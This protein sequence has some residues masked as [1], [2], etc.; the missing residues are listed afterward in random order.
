MGAL[1][2]EVYYGNEDNWGSYQ[3]ICLED[4]VNNFILTYTGDDTLLGKV[5]RDK[6]IYQ[7]KTGIKEF[8]YSIL[9]QP[10]VIELELTDNYD[11]I[12]P[13]DYVN[14][15]RISWVDKRTGKIH[16]MSVNRHTP[17]GV[18]YLQDNSA[19]VLFDNNGQILEGTTILEATNDNLT[20]PPIENSQTFPF[21]PNLGFFT[22]Y[23]I[24]QIWNLDTTKNFNGTFNIDNK[25]I[26]F[27]TDNK[28][29]II[30]L[31]YISDGLAGSENEMC[32]PKLA[33]TALYEFIHYNLAKN[34]IRIPDYEKRNIK[35]AYDTAYRNARLRMLNIK[36]QEFIAQ[37]RQAKIWVR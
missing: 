4:I 27:S 10:K 7:A 22:R 12:L 28:E 29:R 24:E 17:L 21:A 6:V 14:Y 31:E 18:A 34:S 19:S 15:I 11:I 35:K 37:L 5:E 3:F 1:N 25:R 8:T 26:H 36:P 23:D 13:V 32:I 33:E 20:N 9:N 16:P 30:L 2:P